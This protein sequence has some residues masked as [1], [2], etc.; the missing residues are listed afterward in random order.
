M[1]LPLARRARPRRGATLVETTL[2]LSIFLLFLFGLLEY[3]RFVMVYQ[4]M[5]NAAREGARYAIAVI[6]PDTVSN[7]NV[8][9]EVKNRLKGMDRN[10]N[11]FNVTI[12][13]I[14]M[15][16]GVQGT[17]LANRYDASPE[18]GVVVEISYNYKPA[19]PSFLLMKSSV[20]IKARCVMYAEGN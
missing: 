8:E 19:L 3:A 9:T 5:Q 15:R 16:N 1:R 4:A 12:Y 13:A 11:N 18:D 2:V 10:V 20:A 7:T 6:N 17:K 14:V